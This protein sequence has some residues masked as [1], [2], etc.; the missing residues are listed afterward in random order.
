MVV[1]SN[2][3]NVAKMGVT[4]HMMRIFTKY[5]VTQKVSKSDLKWS[6]NTLKVVQNWS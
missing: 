1:G 5:S 6:K 3:D 2:N 4:S